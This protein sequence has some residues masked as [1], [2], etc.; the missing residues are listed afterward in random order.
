M[1]FGTSP[2]V[3]KAS[4]LEI[5]I[6]GTMLNQ[7]TSYKYLGVH[8]DSTLTMNENFQSKYKKLS[9]RLRL[10]SKLRSNLTYHAA[11]TI[12]NSIVVPVFTYCGIV[13]L[14]LPR[15][16]V[17]KLERIQQ[18][19][20]DIITKGKTRNIKL[21]PIVTSVKRHTC[22]LVRNSITKKFPPPMLNYFE[23]ISH[24]KS[25]RN[26]N[27]SIKIPKVKTKIAQNGF[28]YQGAIV[29]NQIPRDIRTQEKD[30]LF[31]S[32]LKQFQF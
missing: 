11:K 23:L 18:R 32:K 31:S 29:Y 30:N 28:F 27:I 7:T 25:T 13:N 16:S 15:T 22:Q 1:I 3:R 4:P 9:S 17:E 19:A 10:L 2:R 20:A 24:T 8:L 5:K 14:N 6:N 21:S 12:Y 26:N